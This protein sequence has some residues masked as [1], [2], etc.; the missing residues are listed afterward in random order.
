MDYAREN[1][2]FHAVAGVEASQTEILTDVVM[3][4]AWVSRG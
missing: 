1:G 4:L 3:A 2:F